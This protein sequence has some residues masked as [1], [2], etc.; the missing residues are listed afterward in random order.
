MSRTTIE[1]GASQRVPEL[2]PGDHLTRPE[3][4]RRYG[5]MPGLKKAELV[6][7]VVYMPSP[8]KDAHAGQHSELNGWLYL[9]RLSTPGVRLA[10]NGTVRLDLS[11]EPQPDLHLRVLPEY[12][13][14]TRLVDDYVEG[15]PELVVEVAG[16]STSYDLHSKLR[17]YERNGV[18]EYLVWRVLDRAIDWFV[19]ENGRFEPLTPGPDGLLRSRVFPGLWLDAEAMVRG[20][21]AAVVKVLQQGLVSPEHRSFVEELDRRHASAR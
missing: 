11:N 17:A 18:C 16:S 6:E 2:Q 8:V 20:D 1:R 21:S 10:D 15:A 14:R 3:F 4:E 9:Y 19:L 5:A 12:G 7:G 13:G